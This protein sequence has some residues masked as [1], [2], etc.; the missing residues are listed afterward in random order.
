ML[1][2]RS[3]GLETGC[4]CS[5]FSDSDCVESASHISSIGSSILAKNDDFLSNVGCIIYNNNKTGKRIKNTALP[6]D[7]FMQTDCLPC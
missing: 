1:P 6:Y 4:L 2:A 5:T 3:N 7:A